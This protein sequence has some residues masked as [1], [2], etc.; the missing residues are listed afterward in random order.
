MANFKIVITKV[1]PH[2]PPY[3]LIRCSK[4]IKFIGAIENIQTKEWD[5]LPVNI[6]CQNL[7]IFLTVFAIQSDLP[8]SPYNLVNQILIKFKKKK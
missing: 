8:I 5:F 2:S 3:A 1:F 4:Y 7:S 6:Y